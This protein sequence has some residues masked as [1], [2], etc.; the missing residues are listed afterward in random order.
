M[1]KGVLYLN[2]M[3]LLFLFGCATSDQPLPSDSDVTE[4]EV[5]VSGLTAYENIR[6]VSLSQT[7]IDLLLE[8]NQTTSEID[9][10]I[11]HDAEEMVFL[12]K[13]GIFYR[14]H[15][16]TLETHDIFNQSQ[17]S[18]DSP[19]PGTLGYDPISSTLYGVQ[20][21]SI[22]YGN[23]TANYL[24]TYQMDT[25]TLSLVSLELDVTSKF[26]HASSA[27]YVINSIGRLHVFSH[28][29]ELIKTYDNDA[30]YLGSTAY[31][32]HK[33]DVAILIGEPYGNQTKITQY[34]T[35]G[36]HEVILDESFTYAK[37]IPVISQDA[38]F[39]LNHHLYRFD[40][41]TLQ[42]N[43][44]PLTTTN[45]T[46]EYIIDDLTYRYHNV[47]ALELSENRTT[48]FNQHMDITQSANA[49]DAFQVGETYY[50][51]FKPNTD[52]I[53]VYNFD[54]EEQFEIEQDF[55]YS[56]VER[57]HLILYTEMSTLMH[58]QD[59]Y[60]D[61]ETLMLSH[62]MSFHAVDDRYVIYA[63]NATEDSYDIVHYDLETETTQTLK[64][65]QFNSDL[66]SNRYTTYT[67][68]NGL[69]V[70][71]DTPSNTLSLFSKDGQFLE[72]VT[73][74]ARYQNQTSGSR[75]Y[76]LRENGEIIS[77]D[78]YV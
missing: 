19:K 50:L 31:Y 73:M 12:K 15:Q 33:E 52:R 64:T 53:Y 22:L 5:L 72:R 16:G 10:V 76:V 9:T 23:S 4:P 29:G 70:I 66:N 43:L 1:K 34:S 36:T 68:S 63:D 77:I 18:L 24:F 60:R 65:L 11:Y 13:N 32:I 30:E 6:H 46:V 38:Y 14:H 44:V 55:Y 40:A 2:I 45:E 56:R 39:T 27:G 67:F 61:G 37:N 75:F 7:F 78:P 57:N 3:M 49:M 58:Y 59:V 62:V 54:D 69:I 74:I 41:E 26:V 17:A 47:Y 8:N 71:G 51:S 48:I 25:Q 42:F 21:Q 35:Q 28:I 20:N